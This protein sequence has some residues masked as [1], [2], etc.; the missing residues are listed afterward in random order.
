MKRAPWL[1]VG[2]GEL[3]DGGT[4][5][6]DPAESRHAS[7][8]LRL[9]A[10]SRVV[11]TDGAGATADG[12]LS[13]PRRGRAEVTIES[14]A[15]EDPPTT[16]MTLAIGLLAGPAMDVVVQKAVELGVTRLAP[17]LCHRSQRGRRRTADRAE[18][19]R[20]IALQALKQCRRPWAMEIG[21]AVSLDE[22]VAATESG[23]GVVA[24]PGG[25]RGCDLAG[26]DQPTLL[27]GPEGGLTDDEEKTLERSRW[28]RLWLGPHV[29][30]AETA[31][32]AGT[33]VL[34]SR[35]D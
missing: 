15:H 5:V 8:A 21:E 32:I 1:L 11:L 14:V 19:W 2:A 29:L 25:D 17:V 12:T 3:E 23:R 26:I 9:T 34:M 18:H 6:L 22:L 13:L 20:R 33:A 16:G 4:A 28:H 24:H 7:G 31:A 30:R 27:V 35:V 10:G